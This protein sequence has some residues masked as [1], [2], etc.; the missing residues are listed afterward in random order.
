MSNWSIGSFNLK[1]KLKLKY[2]LRSELKTKKIESK[3]NLDKETGLPISI[4]DCLPY[5]YVPKTIYASLNPNSLD[6]YVIDFKHKNNTYST[7]LTSKFLK[8]EVKN[9]FLS[10]KYIDFYAIASLHPLNLAETSTDKRY[11]SK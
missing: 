11:F 7:Y 3:I 10:S 6:E 4:T 1:S 2:K 8:I 9:A 5:T